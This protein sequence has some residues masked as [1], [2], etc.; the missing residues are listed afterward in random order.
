M[1]IWQDE[2]A[3]DLGDA[4][5]T[6]VTGPPRAVSPPGACLAVSTPSG[7]RYAARGDARA[8]DA[9]G[10]LE[11][12]V[13]MR[14]DTRTDVGSVTK[15]IATTAAL[16]ALIDAG[17]LSLDDRLGDILGDLLG[18]VRDRARRP[19]AASASD[20]AAATLD[21][22]L[23]HRA[24]LWEWWPLYLVPH[25]DALEAAAGL[26]PRYPRGSARHYSD[27]GFQL[28]GGVVA[29]VAG[30]PLP[31]AVQRLV[32]DPWELADTRFA[33]PAPG[34]EV[35][36]SSNGD[37]IERRMVETGVPYPVE[38]DTARFPW[39]SH[40][41]VGEVNDGNAFHAYGGAAGHAGVFSTVPDMIRAGEA[42]LASLDGH[43]PVGAATARRFVSP[44]PDPTQARGFRR[45]TSEVD[46]CR[47]GAIGHCGFPGVGLAVLPR[48]DAA[49][50]L[51][52]NR[53]HVTGE[54]V[55]LEPMFLAA[56]DGAHRELHRSAMAGA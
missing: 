5:L 12:A 50:A 32:F 2:S 7:R 22:L 47:A 8:F 40:V 15:V 10:P 51:A 42:L 56:L 14:L 19:A 23:Q 17:R 49:V 46:G 44:G 24:G 55:P 6:A 28:L 3:R 35:A 25:D 34:G 11:A 54:P 9:G 20:I 41:L 38:A 26:P 21:D 48:H 13:P 37:A 18:R 52:T 27:L 33:G 4:L 31:A 39:R 36:A 43:G 29:E 53:L 16:M 1:I 45:W 30:Q